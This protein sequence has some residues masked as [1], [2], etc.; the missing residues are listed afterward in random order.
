M[1]EKDKIN[2]DMILDA[3][4]D[5]FV[6]YGFERT[7]LDDI[8]A[9]TELSRP[10]IYNYYKNKK[11]IFRGVALRVHEKGMLRAESALADAK[12]DFQE[13]LHVLFY[14]YSI[15]SMKELA[16]GPHAA[17]LIEQGGKLAQD[18]LKQCADEFKTFLTR[19]IKSADQAGEITLKKSGVSAKE[20]A[21]LL[22]YATKGFKHADLEI[23][24]YEKRLKNLMK[25][26]RAAL[27]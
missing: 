14:E 20:M 7:R 23:T 6:K 8:A 1:S 3:A 19:F 13:K 4:Q 2:R 26:V 16:D 15:I 24:E 22:Y 25:V 12:A 5:C 27:N 11:D 21:D 10:A 9:Q 18:L 17:E